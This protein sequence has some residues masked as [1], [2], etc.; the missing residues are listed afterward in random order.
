MPMK[1]D[2]FLTLLFNEDVELEPTENKKN[3]APT[4]DERVADLLGRAYGHNG[5]F[6]EDQKNWAR[7]AVLERLAE[8]T[9]EELGLTVSEDDEMLSNNPQEQ[10]VDFPA[11]EDD[12][13]LSDNQQTQ[14]GVAMRLAASEDDETL[15]DNQQTP[16][17]QTS[18]D[19][20]RDLGWLEVEGDELLFRADNEG[21]YVHVDSA[22]NKTLSKLIIKKEGQEEESFAL[23]TKDRSYGF[24]RIENI[25]APA[26][27]SV[28]A[29]H[30]QSP[31]THKITWC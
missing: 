9:V 12:E 23:S 25:T 24:Y 30:K 16:E 1:F 13:M 6:T 28:I 2:Q 31:K 8:L 21:V 19:Q 3:D 27:K 5:P 22:T 29:G 20:L 18:D 17:E 15:A 10:I 7:Q 26:M 4:L 14:K 11:S